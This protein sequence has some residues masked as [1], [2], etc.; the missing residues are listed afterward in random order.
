MPRLAGDDRSVRSTNQVVRVDDRVFAFVLLYFHSNVSWS[1]FGSLKARRKEK[2]RCKSTGIG[3]V[4]G[5]G[6]KGWSIDGYIF[7]PDERGNVNEAH[8]CDRGAVPLDARLDGSAGSVDAPGFGGCLFDAAKLH[9][10]GRS[11]MTPCPQC[12]L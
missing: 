4:T 3:N 6:P 2:R 10:C 5:D 11:A 1:A 7:L 9:G 8:V 12:G